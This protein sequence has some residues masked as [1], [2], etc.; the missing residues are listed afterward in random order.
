[1]KYL[2]SA[3]L[4]GCLLSVSASDLKLSE[5]ILYNDD[6][7]AYTLLNVEWDNAWN[8][9]TNHDGV[10][11]FFKFLRGE[12][13]YVHSLIQPDGHTIIA[14]DSKKVIIEVPKDRM[15]LFLRPSANHRGKIR[16]TLKVIID[17]ESLGRF[18]PRFGK[19]SAYGIEMV[20]IPEGSFYLGQEDTTG[21]KFGAV[22]QA[23]AEGE[24]GG[25]YQV[26][27]E[28]ESITIGKEKGNL[29]YRNVDGYQGDQVGELPPAYPKGVAAFWMMKYEPT[30]G[31]YADFLNS[32]SENASQHRVNFGG[33]GYYD[34]GSIYTKVGEYKAKF[35]SAP[36]NHMSWDDAMAYAD[37][38]GL[39]P[40]TELEFTKA[41]RGTAK[42]S[43]GDFPWGNSD[44][45]MLQR[46]VS[47]TGELVM[48][49]GWS[50]SKLTDETKEIFGASAYWV[51]DLAGS[52]W[53]RLIT[54]GSEKG[55]AFT[56]THGDG[57]LTGYGFATNEDW[58]QGV[59][60][61]GVGFRGGGFYGYGRDYH[62]YNPFSPVTY[63]PY[64][65][66][67]GGNR[68][69]AYGARFV[70]TAD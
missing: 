23:N 45:T 42:P 64:G 8:N 48:L 17:L 14:E 50:E 68:T 18:N 40:M 24:F 38:A 54:I 63:R 6:G 7:E 19:F 46:H 60:P 67:P 9:A 41:A 29:Y 1:M 43:P 21:L 16:I 53:E 15:G 10:W 32:L 2:L 12:Q 52:Q 62:D 66:W 70:R 57:R 69:A 28:N 4:C 35:P 27:K 51:M 26:K 55:R 25:L 47:E 34:R 33:K 3:I 22:Y 30:Q 31:Q 49:N 5:P 58:P 37:W 13:G 61:D 11:L 36:C 56:G 44:K 20:K 59:D 39:R 65:G